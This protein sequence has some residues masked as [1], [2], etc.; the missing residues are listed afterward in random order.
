[1]RKHLTPDEEDA[2]VMRTTPRDLEVD[3]H[4]HKALGDLTNSEL[5]I[6]RSA[7]TFERIFRDWAQFDNTIH[8]F[9]GNR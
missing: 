2:Q 9:G 3:R 8:K 5:R 6:G 1:M 4:V 7:K